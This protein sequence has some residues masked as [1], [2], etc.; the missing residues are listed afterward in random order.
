MRKPVI[1]N[2]L[3]RVASPALLRYKVVGVRSYETGDLY[4]LECLSCTHTGD[5]C[6]VLAGFDDFSKLQAIH[7]LNEDPDNRQSHWHGRDCGGSFHFSQNEA[8]RERYIVSVRDAEDEIKR[9]EKTLASK[10]GWL[11][12]LQDGLAAV[13]RKES[14]DA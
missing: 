3:Y 10:R 2:I 14:S 9:D 13:N 6:K 8:L 1:G 4:E 11:Q 5:A 7:M 12:I